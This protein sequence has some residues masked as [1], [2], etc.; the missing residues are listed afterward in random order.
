MKNRQRVY[1]MKKLMLYL[2]YM[3]FVLLLLSFFLFF[4]YSC[5]TLTQLPS[6]RAHFSHNLDAAEHPENGFVYFSET[7]LEVL[8]LYNEDSVRFWL[9]TSDPRTSAGLLLNG[10]SVWIDP[11]AETNQDFGVIYPSASHTLIQKEMKRLRDTVNIDNDTLDDRRFDVSRLIKSVEFRKAVVQ[12][13]DGTNFATA[14]Q[15][16]FYSDSDKTLNYVVTLSFSELGIGKQED[17]RIS[18]GA[19]SEGMELPR[20]DSYNR[21]PGTTGPG[22]RRGYPPGR[23]YPQKE[24]VEQEKPPIS[25]N[26]WMVFVFNGE[27]NETEKIRD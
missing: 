27:N 4:I 1:A 3:P 13:V 11:S 6:T 15:A 2:R 9:R 14:Q 23:H 26:A 5:T 20:N 21:Y 18:V 25:V 12:T 8:G 19:I 10:L 22:D 24:P 7:K 17:L 16:R